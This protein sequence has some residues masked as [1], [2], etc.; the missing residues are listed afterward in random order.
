MIVEKRVTSVSPKDEQL[1]SCSSLVFISSAAT[2]RYNRRVGV[3]CLGSMQIC[4]LLKT[5]PFP[6]FLYIYMHICLFMQ[7]RLF[8]FTVESLYVF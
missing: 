6:L 5:P 8:F 4:K 1:S 2:L 3:D 7:L